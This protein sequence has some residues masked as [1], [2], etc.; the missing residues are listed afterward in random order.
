[1]YIYKQRESQD[2]EWYTE[3]YHSITVLSIF[4]YR[5]KFL[6]HMC[7]DPQALIWFWLMFRLSKLPEFENYGFCESKNCNLG[8]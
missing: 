6:L 3:D 1:M 4:I 7:G 5:C 2:I 8:Y